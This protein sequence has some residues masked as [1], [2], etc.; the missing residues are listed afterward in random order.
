VV[1]N[2]IEA[3]ASHDVRQ[4]VVLSRIVE[5]SH[6]NRRIIFSLKGVKKGFCEV[7]VDPLD[8]AVSQSS[9]YIYV[10]DDEGSR[11]TDE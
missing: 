9:V 8:L 6:K 2:G 7:F 5:I 11:A 3:D 1:V 10:D 4:D